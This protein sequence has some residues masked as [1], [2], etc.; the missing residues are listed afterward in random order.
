MRTPLKWLILLAVLILGA[1]CSDRNSAQAAAAAPPPPTV[2]F[3]QVKRESVAVFHE[4]TAELKPVKTVDIR[5]RVGGTLESASFV[6]G[7]VV[8]QGQ[9]LFQIDPQPYHAD[10]RAAE[11]ALA[12]AEAGL[13]QSR[14]QVAQARGALGQARSAVD[15]E[16]VRLDNVPGALAGGSS[17]MVG[18]TTVLRSVQALG[19]CWLAQPICRSRWHLGQASPPRRRRHRYTAIHCGCASTSRS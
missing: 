10:I 1:G 8:Q 16:K 3:A 19:A 9:V 13:A 17:G 15:V 18:C 12:K 4:Y 6:E 7:S 2:Q 5:T 11:G 14:A